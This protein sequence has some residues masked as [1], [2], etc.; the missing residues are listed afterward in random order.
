MRQYECE[1]F[2][3]PTNEPVEVVVDKKISLLYDLCILH[4]TKMSRDRRET[5]LREILAEY[6]TETQIDQALHDIVRGNKTLNEY[7]EQKGL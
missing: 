4:K 7:L 5:A 3:H 6:C 1:D 2:I